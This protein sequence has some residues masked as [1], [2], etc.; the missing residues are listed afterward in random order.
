MTFVT[1]LKHAADKK[2]ESLPLVKDSI[3]GLKDYSEGKISDFSEVG[4]KAVDDY[5]LEYT[6]NHQKLS[7]IQKQLMV[8]FSQLVQIS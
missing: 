6:L 5:T 7:G 2:S 1:G 8:F 4:V 3:K